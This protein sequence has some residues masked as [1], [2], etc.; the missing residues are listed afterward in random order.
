MFGPSE[1]SC[2]FF[3]IDSYTQLIGKPPFETPEVKATYKKIKACSYS[4]PEHVTISD[5]ARNL[6]S[7][8]LVLDP[9][10][11]PTLQDILS[12][13]FMGDSIPKTMPRSTLAC[14]PAKNF[15]DQHQKPSTQV[16][17]PQLS[18]KPSTALF[19]KSSKKD[20]EKEVTGSKPLSKEGLSSKGENN[21]G[22]TGSH[23]RASSKDIKLG[24][25]APTSINE[26]SSSKK[27]KQSIMLE[28]KE[29]PHSEIHV[30]KWVDYSTKYGLGYLLSDG[31]TG[32]YFNDST[33]II[34]DKN[35]EN[36]EYIEKKQGDKADIFTPYKLSSFPPERELQKK[37]TL[38]QHFRNYLYAETKV[39]A[40]KE[41][42]PDGACCYV[43]KWMKT[44]HAIMFR[45]SNK[46][47]Q[48][49]FTDKTEII[50]SS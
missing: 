5:N 8:I 4:F 16:S 49:N 24:S 12:D 20:I 27:C 47:V 36:F 17:Q 15:M 32:V 45:L 44:K 39:E 13:P 26:P 21:F 42:P 6:I 33:K 46:I 19:E 31:S 11:R 29:H 40:N 35:G 9:S 38:L 34:M 14:P 30:K 25:K 41:T 23:F 43:K 2:N 7:K 28:T 37:V 50:L 1:S 10:K 22:S 48:V 18:N 3:T